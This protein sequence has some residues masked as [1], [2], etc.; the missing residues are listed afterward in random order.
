MSNRQLNAA[1]LH[2]WAMDNPRAAAKL[3][4]ALVKHPGGMVNFLLPET[5][6]WRRGLPGGAPSSSSGPSSPSSD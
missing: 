3:I 5:D 6:Q 1:W 4:E 2:D